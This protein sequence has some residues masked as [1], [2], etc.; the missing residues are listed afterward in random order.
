MKSDPRCEWI[1]VKLVKSFGYGIWGAT[2]KASDKKRAGALNSS[3]PHRRK[4]TEF[5][6]DM[7]YMMKQKVEEKTP[8]EDRREI[9]D[10]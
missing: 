6:L 3:A 10:Q 9:L 5:V 1:F 2:E 7:T 4:T 8:S